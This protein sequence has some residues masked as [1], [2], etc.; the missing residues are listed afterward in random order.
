METSCG[1]PYKELKKAFRQSTPYFKDVTC[2][3][4]ATKAKESATVWAVAVHAQ[5]T[6]NNSKTTL[7]FIF[8]LFLRHESPL[9]PIRYTFFNT[10]HH[11]SFSSIAAYNSISVT[12]SSSLRPQFSP[13]LPLAV[14]PKIFGKL[15][16]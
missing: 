5:Q 9:Y 14:A 15:Y 12:Y 7:F 4:A 16:P 6:I 1:T 11:R 13:P 10:R 8:F 3:C 2:Q